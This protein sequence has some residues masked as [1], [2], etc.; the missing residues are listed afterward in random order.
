MDNLL[1]KHK[2]HSNEKF[3][4]IAYYFFTQKYNWRE[5]FV[6][7]YNEIWS[8][9]NHRVFS[10][11]GTFRFR[12]YGRNIVVSIV[13][14]TEGDAA[15]SHIER[16]KKVIGSFNN[17]WFDKIHSLAWM[18]FMGRILEFCSDADTRT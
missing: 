6:L 9:K 16:N 12:A 14:N 13:D 18:N 11:Q 5:W 15:M 3:T 8:F 10:S 2:G 7:T 1:L 4:S 17:I